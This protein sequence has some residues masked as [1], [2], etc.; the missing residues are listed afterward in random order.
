MKN[1][2]LGK[3]PVNS[4]FWKYAVPSIIAMLAQTTAGLIDSIFIGRF[5]G[6]EGL[7]AI[8]LFFP[9]IGLLIGI[10]A[11]FAI[12]S[13]TLA[14]I[15]LGKNNREKSNNYFNLAIW[16]LSIISISATLIIIAT[17]PFMSKVMSVTG[18]T[19][20]HM[21]TYGFYLSPFF[22]FFMLNFVFSFFLKLDGKPSTVVKITV[23][24]TIINIVL[25]YL[26]VVVFN[27][28]LKGAALA[29]GLSQLIPWTLFILVSLKSNWIY[30]KPVIIAKEIYAI[31]FN[32][33]S[34][35]MSNIAHALSGFIFN[36]MIL[37]QVGVK[38]I[39]AYSIALNLSSIV[40]SIGYGFGESNQSG[41]SFN[42]GAGLLDRV[43]HFRNLTAK[44]NLFAGSIMFIIAFF[45]GGIAAKL[46]VTD[47]ET[48][49]LSQLI[50]KY[51]AVA[52]I[53]MGVNISIGTYYTAINDPIL[54]AGITFYRSLIGLVIGLLI[55]PSILG[56]NGIWV[57][58][59]FT[60]FTSF[61][62]GI[63]LY[64]KKPYGLDKEKALR[65]TA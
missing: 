40:A 56:P 21:H 41:V 52:Y 29:T 46:F 2:Q 9:F 45:F 53:V 33:F 15:E 4:I 11:M 36:I 12:G 43:K 50:M 17:L 18:I 65:M 28:S 34:E 51:Y 63:Y 55:F 1:I 16:V 38:G 19:K 24:G 10:G 3:D 6:P 64:N 42:F 58:I 35:L 48:I 61:I 44:V 25:D 47:L 39:A 5:V 22:I 27:L 37:N 23:S 31:C 49:Q 14:G 8:T 30:R 32:G 7:S 13:S 20:I 59:I 54:S 60:E 62:A 26:L 57:A